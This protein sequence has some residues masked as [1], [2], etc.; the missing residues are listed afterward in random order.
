MRFAA[1]VGLFV[2]L[3]WA[4]L[5]AVMPPPARPFVL[6]L[7]IALAAYAGAPLLRLRGPGRRAIL[8]RLDRVSGL[9][10]R[11]A[12]ALDDELGTR[13]EDPVSRALWDAHRA[14][15]L[16]ETRDI[17]VGLPSP[18]LVEHDRFALR[19]LVLLLVIATWFMAEGERTKRV[20]LAFDWTGPAAP[21]PYRIDAWVTPPAYTGRPPLLLSGVRSGEPVAEGRHA[22]PIDVPAGSVVTIRATGLSTL[23]LRMRGSGFAEVAPDGA[24]PPAGTTERRLKITASGQL[25]LHDVGD[26]D[27]VWSFNAVPD[28]APTIAMTRTPQTVGRNALS[29]AYRLEDD[30]GVVSAEA[31]FRLKEPAPGARPLYELPPLPLALPQARTRSGNGET[32]KDL[33]DHPFAGAKVQLALKARDDAGN[34][35]VSETA[36]LTLPQR[37]FT[38]PLARALVEQRRMLALDAGCRLHVERALDA[39]AIG[40]ERFTPDTAIYLGLRTA[41]W[42]LAAARDD[43]GLREAADYLWQIAVR[44]EDGEMADAER[45]LRAAEDALR[46][47]LERGVGEDE[48]K[49]LTDNLR[50]ALDRFM[51]ELAEEMRRNPNR[52]AEN[53]PLDRNTRVLRPQDLQAMIDRLENLARSGSRDAAQRMLD[54]LQAMLD[55][56]DR[57]RSG[58][59]AEGDGDAID[60]LGDMIRNQQQLRDRT[61]REGREQRDRQRRGEG[62][63]SPSEPGQ[64]FGELQQGQ[65]EVRRQLD[66][67][68]DQ[69]NKMRRDQ[70]DGEGGE[71]DGEQAF[72]RAR[73][74]MREAERQLGAG[75]ADGAVG[76]QGRAIENLRRGA[77]AMARG[78]PGSGRPNPDGSGQSSETDTD[79]L[80]R[81]RSAG[82]DL[83]NDSRDFVP[84]AVDAQRARRVLEELRRRLGDAERPQIE[85]DYLERLLKGF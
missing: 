15:L 11:P 48:L 83:D 78:Q 75:N 46:Q 23:A 18:R 72:G 27:L 60:R 70:G 25:A 1:A 73:D 44:I 54:E 14:R 59:M 20:L 69:L 56:L 64:P 29:L 40:P 85:L 71:G 76:S 68:L 67:L 47:A 13:R 84:D 38:N 9:P 65:E 16:A 39:L 32:V 2:A 42:R 6:F 50:Q 77:Q 61:W 35:G 33:T 24:A 79:P 10:H 4:G 51:R 7:F 19:A 57:S 34:E 55:S 81:P 53:R 62:N 37:A 66:G 36:D 30:Y 80:G 22:G 49:Q 31:G 63:R 43:D 3:S 17:A 8:R 52:Q 12:S 41:Y 74:A 26:A 58:N 45:E 5:W 28:R 82:R 21:A